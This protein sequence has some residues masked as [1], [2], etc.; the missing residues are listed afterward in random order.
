[1]DLGKAILTALWCA[2]VI[3]L[4]APA[5]LVIFGIASGGVGGDFSS[6]LAQVVVMDLVLGVAM[7]AAALVALGYVRC[8]W[9]VVWIAVFK[10][11][12]VVW[13]LAVAGVTTPGALGLGF[14]GA[15]IWAGVAGGSFALIRWNYDKTP[16]PR[17]VAKEF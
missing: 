9:A 7:A 1:M 11:A 10:A 15:A 16:L 17:D 12:I 3:G 2:L 13:I 5:A 4:N 6:G 8:L 14:A